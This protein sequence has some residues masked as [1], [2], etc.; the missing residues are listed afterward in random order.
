[1]GASDFASAAMMADP[2]LFAEDTGDRTA[3]T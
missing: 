2:A 1:M 3:Q